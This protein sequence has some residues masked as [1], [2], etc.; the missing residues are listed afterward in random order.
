M[1]AFQFNWGSNSVVVWDLVF[2]GRAEIIINYYGILQRRRGYLQ[3]PLALTL[4]P[5]TN[6]WKTTADAQH[7]ETSLTSI[8]ALALGSYTSTKYLFI[9]ITQQKTAVI[10]K[11]YVAK[12]TRTKEKKKEKKKKKRTS[13][14]PSAS[15]LQ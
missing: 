14:R 11:R 6:Q 10:P 5:L 7:N 2:R 13:C 8:V 15:Q 4:K 1:C 3:Q 9:W 12:Q